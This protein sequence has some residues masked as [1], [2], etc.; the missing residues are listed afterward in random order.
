M[1]FLDVTGSGEERDRGGSVCN[2]AEAAAVVAIVCALRDRGV[3]IGRT[4][5]LRVLTFYSAQ[6]GELVS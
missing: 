1:T 3:D 5:S 2:R 6:V 4:R